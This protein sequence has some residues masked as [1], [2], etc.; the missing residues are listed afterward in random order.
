MEVPGGGMCQLANFVLGQVDREPGYLW[1]SQRSGYGGV[2]SKDLNFSREAS[3][4]P[5]PR[6]WMPLTHLDG[7]VLQDNPLFLAPSAKWRFSVFVCLLL[8]LFSAVQ[9]ACR[10][11]VPRP[12]TE[13]VLPEVEVPSP[14][15]WT[16]SEFTA[17]CF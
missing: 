10:I 3:F 2:C 11:F 8:L 17:W 9:R 13:P 15:P 5:P 16:T 14:N 1:A 7:A 12:G 6:R 4:D